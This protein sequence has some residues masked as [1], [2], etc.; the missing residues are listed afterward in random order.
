VIPLEGRPQTQGRSER[1]RKSRPRLFPLAEILTYVSLVLGVVVMFFP[2]LWVALS[3]FKPLDELYHIPPALL[4]DHWSLSNYT[5]ELERFPFLAYLVNSVTVTV[6]ATLLTLAINSMAAFALSKYQFRGR[7]LIFLIT[8]STIMI[9][10]QV[11][12]I[13]VYL[14]M[15]K[16]GLVNTLWGLI[17][18]PSATPTGVFLL[19]QY[20]ITIPDE[21]IQAA[22][23]DGAGEWR[24]FTRI[25]LPLTTPALAVLA[26][27]SIVWRWNDFLW[28]LIVINDPDL[29]TLQLGLS[30]FQGALQ[31]EWNYILAMTVLIMIP[32]TLV[33]GFLQRYLITGIATTGLKG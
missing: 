30:R 10:L 14:V 23:I 13:P 2:V 24:I 19:R 15:A 18:P 11:I 29:F 1:Q 20:M 33:F 21:L 27:L 3:S 26:I 6:G 25:I 28:P 8:L 12:M 31:T 9:P 22:R 32:V 4:P 5:E 16:L 7:D 17:I